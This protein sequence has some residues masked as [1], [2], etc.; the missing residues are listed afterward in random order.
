MLYAL[1]IA[2]R[3]LTASKAQTALLVFGVAIGVFIFIFMSALIGGLAEFIITSTA[4]DIDHISI[5][6]EAVDPSLLVPED[7]RKVLLAQQASTRRTPVLKDTDAFMPMI[8]ALP[9]VIA[10]S[11]QINGSGFLVL[12]ALVTQVSIS[13]LE[14]GKESAIVNLARHMIAGTADL[15][16]GGC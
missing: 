12:G 7:G 4:G 3:Y 11:Q 2:A 9:G 14:P 13:G 6:A 10:T 8:E 1:K 5:Q 15:A 16:T